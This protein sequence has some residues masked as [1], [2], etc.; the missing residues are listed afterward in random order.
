MGS[1]SRFHF[2][3]SCWPG[4][5]DIYSTDRSYYSRQY[6]F[7]LAIQCCWPYPGTV[8]IASYFNSTENSYQP[9]AGTL[10]CLFITRDILTACLLNQQDD[11]YAALKTKICASGGVIITV[12][13]VSSL[14]GPSPAP[15]SHL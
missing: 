10:E 9:C 2:E 14:S 12:V 4:S 3:T 7:S 11:F 13:I 5:A 8:L 6:H 15:T 1:A